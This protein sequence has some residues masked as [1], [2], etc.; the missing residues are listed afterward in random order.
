MFDHGGPLISYNSNYF[1]LTRDILLYFFP[2]FFY[3][4]LDNMNTLTRKLNELK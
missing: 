4:K 1:Y 2:K 3:R